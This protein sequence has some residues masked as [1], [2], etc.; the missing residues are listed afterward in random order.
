M[1]EI[2]KLSKVYQ[3]TTILS[4]PHLHIR[5]GERVGLVGNN[6]AGKTTLFRLLLDLIKAS[7]G[8]VNINGQSVHQTT[9]WKNFTGSYLDERFLLGYLS[10]EEYFLF[11][12]Q[13]HALNEAK[14]K[15]RLTPL[16]VM[17]ND[18]ILG[19][20]KYIRA[21]SKGNQK[22]VGIAAALMVDPKVIILDEPFSNLDPT[23]QIH[24]KNLLT[25]LAV[26]S[27]VTLLISSHDLS[28]VTEVCD[29]IIVL[30]RGEV[31]RD[32][33]T[34]ETTLEELNAYFTQTHH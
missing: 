34:D 3:G 8:S 29:R 30:H 15:E 4:V 16:S 9:D 7:S 18:E 14:V 11:V 6:G 17:F 21:L 20:R 1:I 10:P 12:G 5:T 23:A 2:N 27:Q 31:V 32:I 24:L 19:K 26:D 25:T 22:K 33:H 13:L 28:H